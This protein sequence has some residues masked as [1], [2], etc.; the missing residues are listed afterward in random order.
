MEFAKDEVS[1]ELQ[2]VN[3]EI[4]SIN[5]TLSNKDLVKKQQIANSHPIVKYF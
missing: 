3:K 5:Q 4:D 1:K 2:K